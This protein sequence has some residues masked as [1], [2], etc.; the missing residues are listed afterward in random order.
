VI[1]K[2]GFISA[3]LEY[4]NFGQAKF[5]YSKR[6]NGISF[7][8]EERD[9]NDM[10]DVQLGNA[11]T[12]RTGAELAIRKFRVRGGIEMDQSPYANDDSFDLTYNAGIGFRGDA[13]FIDFAYQ[14]FT[15]DKGL[16]PYVVNTVPQ[17]FVTQDISNSRLFLTLAYRWK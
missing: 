12:V 8:D 6:G 17:P 15:L 2:S 9:V 3:E 13:F 7:Q 11:L 5:D 10:I 14:Y 1:A 16:L 4:K